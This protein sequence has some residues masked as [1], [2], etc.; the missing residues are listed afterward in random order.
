MSAAQPGSAGREIPDS[1][2]DF[3]SVASSQDGRNRQDNDHRSTRASTP[4]PKK[5]S[6]V[7]HSSR[8]LQQPSQSSPNYIRHSDNDN[9]SERCGSDSEQSSVVDNLRSSESKHATGGSG[10]DGNRHIVKLLKEAR[11]NVGRLISEEEAKKTQ[12]STRWERTAIQTLTSVEPGEVIGAQAGPTSGA[13]S[14]AEA[15]AEKKSTGRVGDRIPGI[16][17][18]GIACPAEGRPTELD[19]Q[20]VD[21]YCAC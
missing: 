12:V 21:M 11:K 1:Q 20:N 9:D 10:I 6:L 3:P 18:Y 4:Y 13:E 16:R 15:A 5:R 2:P 17:E 7:P 19:D 14:V 8:A